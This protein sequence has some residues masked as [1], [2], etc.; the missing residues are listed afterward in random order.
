MLNSFIG[1]DKSI[2]SN[3]VLAFCS[4]LGSLAC[5]ILCL[6]FVSH[7]DFCFNSMFH[8]LSVAVFKDQDVALRASIL[9]CFNPASIFYSSMYLLKPFSCIMPKS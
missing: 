2:H 6:N 1:I 7:H 3:T 8:R 5:M 4:G 9:F